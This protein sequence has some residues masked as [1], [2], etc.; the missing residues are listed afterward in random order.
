M[1]VK[2]QDSKYLTFRLDLILIF[3]LWSLAFNFLRTKF[4]PD[5]VNS[6]KHREVG[7][8]GQDPENGFHPLEDGSRG[9]QDDAFCSLHEP[10]TTRNLQGFCLGPDVWD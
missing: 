3:E 8:D 1:N 2:V 7:E 10:D 5:K 6:L 4:L 9:E